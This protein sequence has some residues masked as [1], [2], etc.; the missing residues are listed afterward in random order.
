MDDEDDVVVDDEDDDD[1]RRALWM[2]ILER[3]FVGW[4]A[5]YAAAVVSIDCT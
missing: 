5:T 1:L 3:K 4:P 2:D